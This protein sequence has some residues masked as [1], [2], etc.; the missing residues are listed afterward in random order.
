MVFYDTKDQARHDGFRPCHR[1]K[2]DDATF[3]GQREEVVIR[4]LALLRT[5]KD[6]ATMKYGL[7]ELSK[8]V[9]VTPSYLCRVF[10]KTMGVTVGEYI[11]QFEMNVSEGQTESSTQYSES[12]GLGEN[13]IGMGPLTPLAT[14][15][16]PSDTESSVQFP[17]GLDSGMA[18]L[19]AGFS[20]PVT[21][22]SSFLAPIESWPTSS[23]SPSFQTSTGADDAL[24]MYFDFDEWLWTE[25]FSF[26]DWFST[27]HLSND[28]LYE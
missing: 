4:A 3:I 8:E 17:S 23:T 19:E 24:D 11:R 16:T 20:M 1:C 7:K 22:S 15:R 13:S 28:D 25:G 10:K 14:P 18:D 2:P 5:K 9:G 26:S 21:T 6:D 12:V 27:S